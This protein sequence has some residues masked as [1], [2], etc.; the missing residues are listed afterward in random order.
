MSDR[1]FVIAIYRVKRVFPF[2]NVKR[3]GE[4]EVRVENVQFVGGGCLDL[5]HFAEI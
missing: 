1:L 2:Y 4:L 3:K 5:L